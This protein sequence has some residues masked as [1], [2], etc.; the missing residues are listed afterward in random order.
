MIKIGNI[1]IKENVFLAPMSG[2]SDAPFRK[3]VNSFGD[4]LVVS[5]M[6]AS[7][8]MIMETRESMAKLR[9]ADGQDLSVVQLAGCEPEVMAEAARMNEDLGADIIDINFGCPVK[10]VTNGD[11]GSALMRN[12]P[13]ATKLMEATVKAVK[14]PV[15][16]KMRM[17]WDSSSLNAP[18]LAR[19]AE[20]LGIQLLTVHG[21]TRCQM[22]KGSADWS[23]IRNVKDA[24]N[25]PVIA[26]GDI[27][28]FESAERALAESGADGIMVGRG[29]Y[30]KPWLV[31]QITHH[32]NGE[33]APKAPSLAEQQEIVLRHYEEMLELYGDTTGMR[34]ARKH[35]GWYT[36]GLRDSA[37]FRHGF[38]H[39]NSTKEA[40]ITINDFYNR[41]LDEG[42]NASLAEVA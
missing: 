11:A 22:Y 14:V 27:I 28:D 13:L 4:N 10:K 19:I 6:I 32:L 8:A 24:V 16:M 41:V 33:E 37:K 40:K 29:T 20:D 9:K 38:N 15:T 36:S 34:M 5:E 3:L 7:R 30:G 12:V 21:R 35:I 31:N 17:G 1:E 2:V 18:E 39:I 23:F 42:E 25:I 26:N